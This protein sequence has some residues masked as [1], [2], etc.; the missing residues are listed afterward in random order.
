[1]GLTKL[2]PPEKA[3]GR[4]TRSPLHSEDGPRDK[5]HKGGTYP[6]RQAPQVLLFHDH[7]VIMGKKAE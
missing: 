2:I 7:R 6:H 3:L 5:F 1:M 4:V